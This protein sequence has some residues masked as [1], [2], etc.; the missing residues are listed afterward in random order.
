MIDRESATG[1]E[2]PAEGAAVREPIG[3]VH[4][5]SLAKGDLPRQPGLGSGPAGVIELAPWVPAEA[6]ADLDGFERVWVITLLDRARGWRPKVLPPRGD[7]KRG[8]FATRSPHRPNPIGLSCVRLGAIRGRTIEILDHD[9]LDGTPVL[10]VKPYIPAFDAHPDAAAGWAEGGYPRHEIEVAPAAAA[11]LRWLAARGVP[12]DE[13]AHATLALR[14]YP[15]PNHRVTVD[16]RGLHTLAWRTWR[17]DYHLDAA[18]RRVAIVAVRSGL[19]AERDAPIDDPRDTH[20][21][22]RAFRATSFT[23]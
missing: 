15:R 21:I 19:D 9:L 1:D 23:P 5:P 14:P 8:V 6:L 22:H 10:D 3:I 4:A 2:E 20:A 11:A 17:V 12:L 7:A 16:D 13:R 18:A